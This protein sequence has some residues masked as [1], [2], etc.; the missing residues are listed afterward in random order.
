VASIE[1][2]VRPC[3]LEEAYV[4]NQERSRVVLGGFMWMKMGNRNIAEA[5]DLSGL[6][7]D[8]IEES[9]EEFRIGSM[10]SLRSLELHEGIDKEFGGFVRD[11]LHHIVGVQFRNGATVG[12]S[13][14]GRFGFSDV[15]TCLMALDTYAELYKGGIV[16]LKEFAQMKPDT[17][18]LVRVIIKKD[19]RKAS[20]QSQRN[21]RTDFPVIAAAVA[22][23]GDTVYVAVG[24]RPSK[25][26][27]VESTDSGLGQ[28][29]TNEEISKFSD[30]ARDQFTYGSDMRAGGDYR[31]H[32]ASVYIRRGLTE[33][34]GGEKA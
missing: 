6:G 3:S 26:G 18:I 19:G 32:L 22:V 17:D 9:G 1:K 14:Y 25:A 27:L 20:Y 34:L 2:V 31:K 28:G 10:C 15:L 33:L 24:A 8:T 7:L 13:V 4:L 5:I 23:K 16:P 30:W 12:G 11:A 21:T 29:S